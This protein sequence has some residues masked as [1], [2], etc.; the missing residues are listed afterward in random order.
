MTTLRVLPHI[1]SALERGLPVV[2]LETSVLAQ[3]L[4]VPH[5]ADAAARMLG[6]V[7]RAGAV[8]ALTA[9]V[10]GTATLGLTDPELQRFLARTGVRKVSARDLA[11]C[12]VQGADGATTVA[13]SLTLAH[14]GELRVFATGGIGGVHRGAPFDESADLQALAR[15]PLVVVCAGAKSILDLPATLE[16]LETLG[17]PVV[18]YRTDELPGFFTTGTGLRVPQRADSPLEIARIA[19]THWE[20]G[21][22]SAVLVVQPPPADAALERALVDAAVAGAVRE[23]EA[24]GVTGAAVTPFLLG[25]VLAATDG[26]SLPANLALLEANAA[27]AAQVAVALA[28]PLRSDRGAH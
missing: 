24:A 25:A 3:G 15:T 21:E 4:P 26:R 23:A 16:R 20:L 10:A 1:A 18:G 8:A 17:V 9:V 28:A 11:A 2:A 12:M 13:A 6:A 19:R 27:L 7:E 5:N 14:A 22:R